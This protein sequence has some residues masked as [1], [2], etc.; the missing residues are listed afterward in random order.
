[1]KIKKKEM[2]ML[3][4]Y[5]SANIIFSKLSNKSIIIKFSFVSQTSYFLQLPFH[6]RLHI[7]LIECPHVR[8]MQLVV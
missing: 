4:K 1:M 2:Q 3:I 8:K 6:A 5:L 7:S